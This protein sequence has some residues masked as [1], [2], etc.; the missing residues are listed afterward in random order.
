MT[1]FE[2][3]LNLFS[4]AVFSDAEQQRDAILKEME[5]TLQYEVSS[6][7]MALLEESYRHIQ[8]EVAHI[9]A[10]YKQQISREVFEQKRQLL[11]QRDEIIAQVFDHVQ[12]RVEAFTA[13]PDYPAF[14]E[15]SI[16][17]AADQLHGQSLTVLLRNEDSHL[18]PG[19]QQALA[20][21]HI[22]FDTEPGIT[23]GGAII[24]SD[25]SNLISD[26]TLD[27]RL[28]TAR[29]NFVRESGLTLENV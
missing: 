15:R 9:R 11:A 14:L 21:Y 17:S 29:E 22:T 16:R 26:E 2:T 28:H 13:G 27:D 18:V 10:K 7:E 3:K 19:L 20:E 23:L 6:A 1:K 12:Q 5:D 8:T 25:D 4:Q 24:R